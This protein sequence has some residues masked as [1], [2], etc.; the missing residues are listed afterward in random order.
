MVPTDSDKV[1]SEVDVKAAKET[2]DVSSALACA[3]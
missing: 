2:T 1:L 3:P